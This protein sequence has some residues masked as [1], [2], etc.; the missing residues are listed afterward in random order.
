MQCPYIGRVSL[1]GKCSPPKVLAPRKFDEKDNRVNL[2]RCKKNKFYDATVCRHLCSMTLVLKS[3]KT[4]QVNGC[5]KICFELT[6]SHESA[7][8]ICPYQKYCP[9]GCPCKHYVC[10]KITENDQERIPVW[11]LGSKTTEKPKDVDM[12][13]YERMKS[14]KREQET[15]S[16]NVHLHSF[17]Q[18]N[19]S[20]DIYVKSG[21]IFSHERIRN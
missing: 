18:K 15:A 8:E 4:S 2:R 1:H 9:N 17:I 12:N 21:A 19:S 10:D 11:D 20:E 5:E 14:I 16:F 7:G 6:K 3:K 13:I